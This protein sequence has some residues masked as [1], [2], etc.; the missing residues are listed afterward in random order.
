ML[1]ET[2]LQPAVFDALALGGFL[3][4]F[5]F[6]AKN[7]FLHFF[8]KIKILQQIF[9]FFAFFCTFFMFFLINLKINFGEFRFFAVFAFFLALTIQRFFVLNFVAKPATLCYNKFKEKRNGQKGK[10]IAKHTAK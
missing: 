5:L 8:K 2:L 10:F 3:C 6:D 9:N 1:Y 4:G 7:I